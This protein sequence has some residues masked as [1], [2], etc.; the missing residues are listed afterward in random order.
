MAAIK[1]CYNYVKSE[2]DRL[3]HFMSLFINIALWNK[4]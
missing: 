3:E 2:I 1:F 4:F